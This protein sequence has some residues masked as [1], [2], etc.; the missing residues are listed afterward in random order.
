MIRATQLQTAR[1][2]LHKNFLAGIPAPTIEHLTTELVGLPLQPDRPL[3]GAQHRL[4]PTTDRQAIRDAALTEH[5]LISGRLMRQARYLIHRDEFVSLHTATARQ[6][7]QGFNA[8]FRLW[9]IDN[10]EVDR[11]SQAILAALG[12]EPLT[13]SQLTAALASDT[14]R[15]L[16]QT[17]RGG[18]VSKTTN[19]AL[20]LDW[21]VAEGQLYRPPAELITCEPTYQPLSQA[22]PQL[23]L[24]SRPSEAEAQTVLVRRYL[25]TFGPTTEADISF[26]TG[27]GKSETARAVG[28]LASETTMVMVDGIPGM[29]LLLKSQTDELKA[30]P[31][32]ADP[33][34]N[35]LP[36]DDPFVTAHRASRSRY[37]N[38]Q[39]LARKVFNSAGNA[40]P[41][42]VVNGKIVATWQWSPSEG[43]SWQIL[44]ETDSA[45]NPLIETYLASVHD[46]LAD[47][48]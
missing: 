20:V 27:F 35:I 43:L 5:R 9:G 47:D 11:L 4:P 41:T 37:F 29:L 7:K 30:T 39:K 23:D 26:W 40:Q 45:L 12:D 17:S 28:K 18:R 10:E 19:L 21:L 38:D 2:I 46:L 31:R 14:V 15:E 34:V 33:I 3:L 25:A 8:E 6:R 1:F 44:A 36:A 32:L 42:I 48:S 16:S 22:Y 24:T 13:E